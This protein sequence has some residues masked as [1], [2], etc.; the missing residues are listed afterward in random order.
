MT[1]QTMEESQ[2]LLSE[3]MMNV[4]AVSQQSLAT[5][6]QVAALSSEQLRII[7]EIVDLSTKLEVLSNA[8]QNS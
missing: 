8:L 1:K 2:I 3:S 5:S 4:S 6:E 7:D